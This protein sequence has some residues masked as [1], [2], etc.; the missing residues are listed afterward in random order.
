M[1]D[2]ACVTN[3]VA[4]RDLDKI[5]SKT[6]WRFLARLLVGC[7]QS[8]DTEHDAASNTIVSNPVHKINQSKTTTE[9]KN[10]VAILQSCFTLICVW[11]EASSAYKI[12]TDQI[13]TA[14][15]KKQTNAQTNTLCVHTYIYTC[16]SYLT[17]I[18]GCLLLA[19]LANGGGRWGGRLDGYAV[20]YSR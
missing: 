12:H 6:A 16:M 4:T 11:S 20:P 9:I 7:K 14:K 13:D 18:A 5:Y 17:L 2:T 15:P 19:A 8:A 10:K 3:R 1:P